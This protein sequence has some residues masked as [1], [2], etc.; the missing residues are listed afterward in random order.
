M[1]TEKVILNVYA[2][3]DAQ[4]YFCDVTSLMNGDDV[5]CGVHDA[6]ILPL[7]LLDL[8]LQN[9]YFIHFM[10]NIQTIKGEEMRKKEEKK[11][12]YYFYPLGFVPAPVN[13]SFTEV[14]FS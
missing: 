4:M 8:D 6:L 12:P 13:K 1:L 3:S 11:Y 10:R 5:L 9:R 2:G 7:I 14:F